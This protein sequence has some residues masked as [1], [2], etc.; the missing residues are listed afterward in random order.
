MWFSRIKSE[1]LRLYLRG[2]RILEEKQ[3][4]R[5]GIYLYVGF[6]YY[7]LIEFHRTFFQEE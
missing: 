3:Q 2:V 4:K 6:C 5:L 7:L 1:N